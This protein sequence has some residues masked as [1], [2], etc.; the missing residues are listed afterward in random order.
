MTPNKFFK[1]SPVLESDLD[2]RIFDL[3]IGRILKKIY[4]GLDGKEKEGAVK[5]FLF[6]DNKKREAFVKKYI[7]NFKKLFE[8]ETKK[9]EE[10]IE[11]E[12]EKQF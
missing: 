1:K 12:I 8:E 5:T 2:S 7:P 11:A 4:L 6:N 3:V 10:E 9:I